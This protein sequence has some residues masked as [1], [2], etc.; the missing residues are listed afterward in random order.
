[1]PSLWKDVYHAW[2]ETVPSGHPQWKAYSD[3][4]VELEPETLF[5][6]RLYLEK[7]MS[8]RVLPVFVPAGCLEAAYSVLWNAGRIKAAPLVKYDRRGYYLVVYSADYD[9]ALDI[10]CRWLANID[11]RKPKARKWFVNQLAAAG[12]DTV[13]GVLAQADLSRIRLITRQ[14]GWFGVRV[15]TPFNV[16]LH[17]RARVTLNDA[18]VEHVEVMD[19]S[20]WAVFVM[21]DKGPWFVLVYQDERALRQEYEPDKG[22]FPT[23]LADRLW[24]AGFY[25]RLAS[26]AEICQVEPGEELPRAALDVNYVTYVFVQG[27]VELSIGSDP[28]IRLHSRE[29]W[30]AICSRPID[31]PHFS[32][33]DVR[34]RANKP[35]N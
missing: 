13:S 24:S 18:S 1:M 15:W 26:D 6:L 23:G 7:K 19:H 16:L 25:A 31:D 29:S 12:F 3:A 21:M 20:S 10:L 8:R 32:W 35:S 34:V 33:T 11:L 28:W 17:G 14:E 30:A 4:E 2:C 5:R 27:T 9:Q 22:G